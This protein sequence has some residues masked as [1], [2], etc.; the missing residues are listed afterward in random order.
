M[1]VTLPLGGPGL[2]ALGHIRASAPRRGS[3]IVGGEPPSPPE[4]P[5]LCLPQGLEVA[6]P[7]SPQPG[8]AG[9]G[10]P[11]EQVGRQ[12]GGLGCAVDSDGQFPLEG[13]DARS[14]PGTAPVGARRL[15]ASPHPLSAKGLGTPASSI[16]T[17]R[18]DDPLSFLLQTPGVAC[19]PWSCFWTLTGWG[20]R[21]RGE[22]TKVS[23]PC[24]AWPLGAGER[25][26]VQPQPGH[27]CS[28]AQSRLLEG[29]HTHQGE[30]CCGL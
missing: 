16:I 6:R 12:S 9:P 17:G 11:Q 5:E 3:G 27:V 26:Q 13:S 28:R 22:G 25:W 21:V 14:L 30:V 8:G 10:T 2:P 19:D 18:L 4:M 23:R 7:A 15:P 24:T 1:Q 29:S 20:W